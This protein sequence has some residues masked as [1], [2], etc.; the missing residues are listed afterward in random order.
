MTRRVAGGHQ[1][2]S[3]IAAPL[4]LAALLLP[5]A[6][7]GCGGGGTSD[8]GSTPAAAAPQAARQV[9]EKDY[10][11]GGFADSP[12]IDN[13]WFPLAPG[14][15]LVYTGTI[16]AE[17]KR[18][19]HRVVF[20]GTDLTKLSA[21][22][23]WRSCSTATTTRASW[24]RPSSPSTRRTRPA[25]SGTWASTRRSTRRGSSPGRRTPGSPGRRRR[26]RAS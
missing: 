2:A 22:V 9:T 13:R 12:R 8:K 18:V 19:E 15:Q 14:T 21:G 20:T 17:G 7:A 25:T 24:P 4:A 26:R 6:L 11:R 1:S 3:R 23:R 5:L 10:D 16:I